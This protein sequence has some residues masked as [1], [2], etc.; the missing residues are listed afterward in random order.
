MV[1]YTGRESG[2]HARQQPAHPADILFEAADH[3]LDGWPIVGKIL[4]GGLDFLDFPTE[5]F[6]PPTQLRHPIAIIAPQRLLH[7]VGYASLWRQLQL[8][9]LLN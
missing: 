8:I 2:R 3:K 5:L 6:L 7:H 4:R 9:L 1:H